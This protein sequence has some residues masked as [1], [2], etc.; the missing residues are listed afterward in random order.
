MH[1]W[2]LHLQHDTLNNY[3]CCS[4][5]HPQPQ[6]VELVSMLLLTPS[7]EKLASE[8]L[9]FEGALGDGYVL[10]VAVAHC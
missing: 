7:R 4:P 9:D 3:E 8:A 1:F 5:L 2:W 6:L 10:T